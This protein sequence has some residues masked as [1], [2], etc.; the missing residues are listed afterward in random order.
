MG[1]VEPTLTP[2]GE[3]ELLVILSLAHGRALGAVPS[4]ATLLCG[5]AQVALETGRGQK[6]RQHNVGGITAGSS[7]K[8]QGKPWF[9]S[10]VTGMSFRAYPTFEAG[11]D[12]YWTQIHDRWLDA[13]LKFG[14]ADPY[15]AALAMQTYYG[16]L[17]HAPHYPASMRSL[18]EEYRERPGINIVAPMAKG[19]PGTRR[20]GLRVAVALTTT[21]LAAGAVWLLPKTKPSRS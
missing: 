2:A 10:A 21:A 15:G 18:Y 12:D 7:W 11:A 5:L 17:A 4:G 16:G 13:Y 9:A 1:Q 19:L 6:V 14:E 3:E 20:W 8:A